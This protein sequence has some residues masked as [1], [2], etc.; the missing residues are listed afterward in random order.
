MY[1]VTEDKWHPFPATLDTGTPDNWIC[2]SSLAALALEQRIE[3]TE[4]EFMDFG[5]KTVKSSE[6][7]E[8][9]W[10]AAEG[11]RKLRT[12]KFRIANKYAPF[13]VILGCHL[14]LVEE[15]ILKFDKTAWILAKKNATDGKHDSLTVKC[16]SLPPLTSHLLG[17]EEKLYMERERAKAVEESKKLAE[18]KK[19]HISGKS[20]GQGRE[21][22][23]PG[24]K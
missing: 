21:A 2:E 14:L 24:R 7:V 1:S 10:C 3:T 23:L 18:R 17:I 15:G 13:D 12:S 5:G 16:V 6:M 20:L 9:P 4:V 11:N 8:I 19:N 22:Q